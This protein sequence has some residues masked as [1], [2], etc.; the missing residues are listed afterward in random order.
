MLAADHVPMSKGKA[1]AGAVRAKPFDRGSENLNIYPEGGEKGLGVK[2][3][4]TDPKCLQVYRLT[5]F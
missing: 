2:A 4:F 1:L 5:L 3:I